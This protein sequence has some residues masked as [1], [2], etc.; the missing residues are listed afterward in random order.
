LKSGDANMKDAFSWC[1]ILS[2]Y[3]VVPLIV[4]AVLAVSAIPLAIAVIIRGV[5]SIIR[6]ALA[7]YILS[8]L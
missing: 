6:T 5:I 2:F 3:K 1:N 8:H 7:A 4:L